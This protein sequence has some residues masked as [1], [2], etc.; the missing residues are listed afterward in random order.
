MFSTAKK[1]VIVIFSFL[2]LGTLPSAIA[3]TETAPP[4]SLQDT[5]VR[6]F[7]SDIV[8]AD[9]QLYISLPRDYDKQTVSYPIVYVLDADYCFALVHQIVRFLSDRDEVS[10]LIVVGV[11]Y[12][13]VAQEKSGPIHKL[14]RTRDYTPTHMDKGGYGEE[15]QKQSGGGGRFLRC[16]EQEL[17]PYIESK[18]RVKHD[19]TIV[20]YSFGGLFGCFSMVTHPTLFQ[21]YIIVS[22]SLWYGNHVLTKIERESALA[23]KNLCANAF[24]AVGGRERG[25]QGQE[26]MVKDLESFVVKLRSRSYCGLRSQLWVA[27]GETHQSVFPSAVTRGIRYVFSNSP[28]VE[29]AK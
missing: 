14:S 27:D 4:Y 6:K 5:Q 3:E 10:P 24:F 1:I 19:R 23:T 29:K 11:A 17:I 12:P 15:F 20:G 8:K 16:F 28:P 13:G 22:P 21:R 7:H 18:F 9:Y 2:S 26:E 25:F